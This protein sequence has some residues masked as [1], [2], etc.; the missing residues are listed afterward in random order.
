MLEVQELPERAQ[1]VAE[2]YTDDDKMYM[3]FQNGE[4]TF[5]RFNGK[6]WN[7]GSNVSVS[8]V[9]SELYETFEPVNVYGRESPCVPRDVFY[10]KL[11]HVQIVYG[12][13]GF[14]VKTQD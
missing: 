2:V 13:V 10:D 7:A 14:N 5:L 3:F 4:T 12:Y 11:H 1:P 6:V 9:M 8:N